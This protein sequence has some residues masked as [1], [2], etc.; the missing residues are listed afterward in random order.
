MGF[1]LNPQKVKLF[2][3]GSTATKQ[4]CV[5]VCL[6]FEGTHCVVRSMQRV[7][8]AC[9]LGERQCLRFIMDEMTEGEKAMGVVLLVSL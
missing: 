5:C 7:A 2:A 6:F 8:M 3:E 1:P 4:V 9:L